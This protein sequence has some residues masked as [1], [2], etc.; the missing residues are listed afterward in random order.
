MADE[1]YYA[2]D[3]T[4]LGPFSGQQLKN[5]AIVGDIIPSDTVWKQGVEKGVL[6]SR[7]KYLFAL[8]AV[9]VSVSLAEMPVFSPMPPAAEKSVPDV[10]PT[11]SPPPE[12]VPPPGQVDSETVLATSVISES[13]SP[14]TPTRS[15]V[16]PKPARKGRAIALKG[17]DIVS[18][19]GTQAKYR[20]KCTECGHKDGGCQSIPITT[21][22]TKTG[23][24]C[25]K[26]RKKREVIIQCIMS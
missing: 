20:R 22:T 13:K 9:I 12:A 11:S 1:W 5:L 14:S 24:Y 26:C 4:R 23:Y 10:E 21:K 16:A 7:V 3:A 19:D 8:P 2:H 15:T 18:Q 17:A 6:A 25:P